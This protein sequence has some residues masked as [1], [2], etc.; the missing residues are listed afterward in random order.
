MKKP[1]LNEVTRMQRLAGILTESYEGTQSEIPETA[2]EET[3]DE[4]FGLGAKVEISDKADKNKK[5]KL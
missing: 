1:L 4:L 5:V 2:H 3:V